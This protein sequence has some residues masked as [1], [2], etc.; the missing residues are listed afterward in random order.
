MWLT[1]PNNPTGNV[2]EESELRQI[3]EL[4]TLVV[5][6][7]AYIEVALPVLYPPFPSFCTGLCTAQPPA[8]RAPPSRPLS[9]GVLRSL[10]LLRLPLSLS[11]HIFACSSLQGF[12]TMCNAFVRV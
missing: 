7:E 1:S 12:K 4:D 8:T 5:L 3:L 6:D 9:S 10:W 11:A 2:I